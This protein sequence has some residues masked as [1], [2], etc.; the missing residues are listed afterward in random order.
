M[1]GPEHVMTSGELLQRAQA[2]DRW[3]LERLL[4]LY[5]PRMRRWASGRLPGA[6][7]DM[8]DTADV[9]QDTLV[10]ALGRIGQLEIGHDGALQ[11]YLRRALQNRLND[12]YR[13]SGR[14]PDRTGI[15]GELEAAD[16]SPLEAAI[17]AEAV[18][19]YEAAL[20]RLSPGDREAVILR[21]EMCC[22]YDE[23]AMALQKSSA[24]HARVAVSRALTRLAR[25]MSNG[26]P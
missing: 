19:R 9:V 22:P 20:D 6:A 11:A 16:P 7:R 25:E 17:G 24:A 14:S 18:T 23:I 5:L 12:L 21:I 8:L 13:R 1:S 4:A 2:G 15:D 26:R 3:A 10:A